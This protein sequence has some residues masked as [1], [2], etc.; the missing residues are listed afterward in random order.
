VHVYAPRLRAMTKYRWED[1]TLVRTD[2]ESAG[3]W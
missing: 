2:T 1:D 3:V